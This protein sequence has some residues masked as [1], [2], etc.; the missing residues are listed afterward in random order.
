MSHRA[1]AT[2]VTMTSLLIGC[3]AHES[4]P[5]S[6]AV[7]AMISRCTDQVVDLVA[8]GD[9]I[10]EWVE[11]TLPIADL[12]SRLE[13]ENHRC[14]ISE[15]RLH[16]GSLKLSM[17]HLIEIGMLADSFHAK[18]YYERDGKLNDIIFVK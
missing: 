15:I 1:L 14:Q 11:D 7:P 2:I 12:Q 4:R 5:E 6:P 16:P 9:R 17:Q 10:Y 8:A 3:S 18:A 13:A